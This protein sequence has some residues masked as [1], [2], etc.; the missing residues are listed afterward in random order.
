[1]RRRFSIKTLLGIVLVAA[2]I[3]AAYVRIRPGPTWNQVGGMIDWS[4]AAIESRLGP[5]TLV[6]EGDA[7]DANARQ[8][9]LRPP[10]ACRT[11]VFRTFDGEFV[12]RL[13]L[14]K[15]EFVCFGS[16]WTNKGIYY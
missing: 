4:Q 9:R 5:P 3:L 16:S 11:L 1:M 14:A 15:D 8:I 7:G 13:K 12:V 2:M 6:V 10:G